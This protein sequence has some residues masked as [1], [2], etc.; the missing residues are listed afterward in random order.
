LIG[1]NSS[2]KTGCVMQEFTGKISAILAAAGKGTRFG[3]NKPKQFVSYQGKPL[4]LHSLFTMINSQLFHS[5]VVVVTPGMIEETDNILSQF[6]VP[7]DQVMVV[8]GGEERFDS[9]YKGITRLD[10]DVELVVIHDGA[11]PNATMDLFKTA[12]KYG[13]RY[14]AATCGLKISDTIKR[15]DTDNLVIETIDRNGVYAIQTPQSFNLSWLIEGFEQFYSGKK[16]ELVTDEAML[17]EAMGKQVYIFEGERENL[18]IT[19]AKDLESLTPQINFPRVGQ[20]YDVH[21]FAPKRDL[22]LG[23]VTIPYHLGLAGHSDADVLT[24]SLCDAL[25]GAAGLGDIGQHFPDSSDEYQGISSL[26]LLVRV[27]SLLKNLGFAPLQA[28]LTVICQ[29]PKIAP[30]IE[31]MKENLGQR[32][33]IDNSLIN[34]K[35]T[36]TEKL[37]WEGEEKGIAAMAIAMVIAKNPR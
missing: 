7:R 5:I 11:R 29:Q 1:L 34:I 20:G 3:S 32:L 8:E 13:V 19:F 2:L 12:V 27:V 6:Q 35:A 18:K 22:V 4:F 37:G 36:T 16:R 14:G 28:D 15:V 10:P 24:H 21:P 25:L 30:Y 33:E 31:D 26:I 9:V 23:G 17:I